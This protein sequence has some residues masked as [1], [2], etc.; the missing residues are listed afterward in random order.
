MGSRLDGRGKGRKRQ[1]IALEYEGESPFRLHTHSAADCLVS[2]P[3]GSGTGTELP[4]K[5][6]QEFPSIHSSNSPCQYGG[7]LLHSAGQHCDSLQSPYTS[8]PPTLVKAEPTEALGHQFVSYSTGATSYQATFTA[9]H[10]S[11]PYMHTAADQ[12]TSTPSPKNPG[13]LFSSDPFKSVPCP[14][15]PTY[16]QAPAF[17]PLAGCSTNGTTHG[18][19]GSNGYSLHSAPVSLTA[20]LTADPTS[21]T[22]D[23]VTSSSQRMLPEQPPTAQ[24]AGDFSFSPWGLA[25][26]PPGGGLTFG[27]LAG[28]DMSQSL[29][30]GPGL[31]VSMEEREQDDKKG[32]LGTPSKEKSPRGGRRRVKREEEDDG[33]E[34]PLWRQQLENISKMREIRDAPVDLMGAHKNAEQTTHVTPEVRLRGVLRVADTVTLLWYC[35]TLLLPACGIILFSSYRQVRRYQVLVSL[36]LSSQTKD[37]ITAQ[38]MAALKKHGLTIENILNTP[39]EEVAKLIHP[40]GFWRVSGHSTDM[41][42]DQRN[43]CMYCMLVCRRRLTTSRGRHK[44]CWTSMEVI[45]LPPWRGWSVTACAQPQQTPTC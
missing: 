7:E 37:Q 9:G 15:A 14:Q 42:S 8:Y 6:K 10:P 21:L 30:E 24:F 28:V 17:H 22:A 19:Y 26:G 2:S 5:V 32:I 29:A 39:E 11:F 40:V 31:N 43:M 41:M 3:P 20:S 16:Y 35:P 18:P 33:W 1:H 27:S 38:A 12:N 36:M 34:P 23:P 44:S 4:V 25:A 13:F 45:S